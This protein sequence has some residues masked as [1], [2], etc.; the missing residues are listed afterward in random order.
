[1]DKALLDLYADYLISSFSA[2][3]ATGLADVLDQAIS[4]DQITR[5]LAARP[6]TSADLWHLVKP[7]VRQVESAEGVLIVDDRIEEKP[8]TDENELIT[9]HFDHSKD[10]VVKGINFLTTLYCV[11]AVSLPVAYE[12]VTKTETVVDKKT[13]KPRKKSA[14]TKNAR[15]RTMLRACRR[16]QIPCRFVLNDVWSASAENMQF[17]KHDLQ[18]DFIMP[19]KANRKVAL[20]LADKHCGVYVA[21]EAL[22][23]EADTLQ[24]VYLDEVDFPLLLTKHVFTNE[25]GGTGVLYLVTSDVTL[26]AEQ[27]VTFYHTRWKVEQYHKSLKQ[28]ASLAKSPTRT[29]VTQSNHFFAAV[30]AF[31]KLE[32]LKR[33]TSLN[34]FALKSKIYLAALHTAFGELQR[35]APTELVHPATA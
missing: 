5:F 1:M 22:A 15:Y 3:T 6:L 13:G 27:I 29:V 26:T 19:I 25:D 30:C 18:Q 33:K 17:V 16:N 34:H 7:L 14:V 4:H 2:T 24:E 9:W 31:I 23:L 28:N 20:S 21:V 32:S 10:R 35:L 11:G 12:L 8:Y